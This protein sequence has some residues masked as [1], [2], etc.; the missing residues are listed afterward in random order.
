ME[1]DFKCLSYTFRE[2]PVQDIPSVGREIKKFIDRKNIESHVFIQTCNRAEAYFFSNSL[3]NSIPDKAIL[4]EGKEALNHL[5]EVTAGVDSLIVGETE[6]LSQV[7]E[8]FKNSV[9]K[10]QIGPKLKGVFDWAL[11][12]GKKVRRET[13]ISTGKVSVASIGLDHAQDILKEF[14]GKKAIIIGAGKIGTTA[15]RFLKDAGIG[16]IFVANRTYERAVELSKEV[17]GESYRLSRFPELLPEV[18]IIICATSAP[19]YILTEDK[20]PELSEKKV[21]LDLSVPT[22]V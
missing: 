1:N 15:A 11:E 3:E 2:G 20:I 22:N 19:H 4:R 9:R 14:T 13:E 17:G 8:A 21:L 7:R 16:S 10:N 5:L 12:F 6:I 18:E